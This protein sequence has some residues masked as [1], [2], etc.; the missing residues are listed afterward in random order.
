[1]FPYRDD[2][3]MLATPVVTI[4]LIAANILMWVM[5]QG[6]GA[7]PRLSASVCE[8][9]LIPGELFGR[10]PEG[11]RLPIAPGAACELGGEPV[12]YTPLTSM[13][14]H[15]GWLHLIGNMWFL[16]VFGNNVED[17]MGRVRYLVFYLLCGIAAAAVQSLLDPSSPIPMVGASGAI[18][19]VMG[20][21]LVLY[22]RVR[23][24][25]MVPLGFMFTTMAL[26][27]WAMLLY[28]GFLQFVGGLSS[29]GA[30]GGGVAFWAHVGGFVA[31]VVLVKLFARR[32][33]V[34]QHKSHHWRP[35][36]M[37]TR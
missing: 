13:F 25:T 36:G 31:G 1:M 26:P 4:V 22:P 11:F 2:N 35:A 29:L 15:G 33:R 14:L 12:W 30:E 10:L 8:L 28:W 34:A 9:G 24:F 5:V 18:S 32:D 23:V 7:E 20:A 17:S 27:A 3:P 37:H 16:W 19:G 6:M 21:Y